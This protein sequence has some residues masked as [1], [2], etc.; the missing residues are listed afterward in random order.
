MKVGELSRWN[1][2][3]AAMWSDLVVVLF[4]DRG[5]IPCLLQC[6][7]PALIEVFIPKLAVETLDIAVLHW[8]TRLNQDMTNAMCLCPCHEHP[9]GELRAVVGSHHIW[10]AP[11]HGCPV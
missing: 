10:I 3:N 6:L 11:E 8:A 9:A 1:S 2:S 4:P 7:K 5:R